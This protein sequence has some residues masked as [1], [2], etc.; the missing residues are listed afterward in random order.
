MLCCVNNGDASTDTEKE[1]EPVL[2]VIICISIYTMLN[3]DG[4]AN[5]D[6]K[7]EQALTFF[8][9]Y[10][11]YHRFCPFKNGFNVFLLCCLHV[12]FTR[13][14]VPLTNTET[15]MI[16]VKR[17]LRPVSV[18]TICRQCCGYY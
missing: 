2:C 5:A 15:L 7:C 13:S 16:R 4:E 12:T 10:R 6:K 18:V 17:P 8:Y 9:R 1:S 3:F 14:K 11:Q